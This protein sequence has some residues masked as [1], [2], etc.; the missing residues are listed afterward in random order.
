MRHTMLLSLAGAVG[1]FA[2]TALADC[3]GA[4]CEDFVPMFFSMSSVPG[5]CQ[6]GSEDPKSHPSFTGDTGAMISRFPFY[7][8]VVGMRDFITPKVMHDTAGKKT[9]DPLLVADSEN[10]FIFDDGWWILNSPFRDRFY[11]VLTGFEITK[12]MP[13][14]HHRSVEEGSGHGVYFMGD[15]DSD[16]CEDQMFWAGD[17]RDSSQFHGIHTPVGWF[18][19]QLGYFGNCFLV[20]GTGVFTGMKGEITVHVQAMEPDGFSSNSNGGYETPG[21]A[22]FVDSTQRAQVKIG[23]LFGAALCQVPVDRGADPKE[24]CNVRMAPVNLTYTGTATFGNV[25]GG[26]TDCGRTPDPLEL[27]LGPGCSDDCQQCVETGD[28]C[29]E[30]G[31]CC[32]GHLGN[33]MCVNGTC[34]DVCVAAGGGCFAASDCCSETCSGGACS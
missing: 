6:M 7:R 12:Q 11:L 8:G 32:G 9:G 20:G 3:G 15:V 16:G 5:T 22:N 23:N 10:G 21:L 2:T 34:Q 26:P 31:E 17:H 14:Y 25:S 13:D 19:Q 30:S 18:P 27:G 4:D 28:P 33:A 24:P 1:L 29:K